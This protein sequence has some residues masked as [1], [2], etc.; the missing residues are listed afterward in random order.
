MRKIVS[1]VLCA[2]LV[3]TFAAACGKSKAVEETPPSTAETP[4]ETTTAPAPTTKAT[5]EETTS[6]PQITEPINFIMF[7]IDT[8]GYTRVDVD[9]SDMIMCVSLDPKSKTIR[10]ISLLRD[11]KAQIEGHDPQKMNAAYQFGGAKLALQTVNENFGLEYEDYITL[12]WSDVAILV[13]EIGGVDV[14]ITDAEAEQVNN[15]VYRDVA[16]DGRNVYCTDLSGGL[17]HLDGTQALHFSRIRKIDSDYYRAKRQ[18]RT[19]TAI[20]EKIK[21]M[22]VTKYPGLIKVFAETVE[23]TSF[24]VEDILPWTTM[25][26]DKYKIESYVIPD[27][28]YEPD[29]WGGVDDTGAWVWIY[30]M[31]AAGDRLKKILSGEFVSK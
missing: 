5:T 25:G 10:F 28:D 2:A 19:L 4:A 21:T 30:D 20:I 13:D 6:A 26:L 8:H 29:L 3:L 7:G 14:E 9:K 16:R 22:P 15:M 1:L 11:T 23:E 17:V 18:H 31:K 24:T 27:P 12:D